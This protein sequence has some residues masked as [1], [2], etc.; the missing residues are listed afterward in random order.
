MKHLLKATD[1]DKPTK[2]RLTKCSRTVLPAE[3]TGWASEVD[4]PDCLALMAK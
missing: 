2:Y 1:A 3:A 4:C